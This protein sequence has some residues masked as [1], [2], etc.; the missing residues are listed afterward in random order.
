[1]VLTKPEITVPAPFGGLEN[2]AT[3]MA[4]QPIRRPFGAES[5]LNKSIGGYPTV[6]SLANSASAFFESYGTPS[7][8]GKELEATGDPNAAALGLNVAAAAALY[9]QQ[10]QQQQP[11]QFRQNFQHQ[12]TMLGFGLPDLVSCLYAKKET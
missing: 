11:Q 2:S 7:T 3:M 8:G 1:M 9:M 10:H 5:W 4:P 6:T 12:Q